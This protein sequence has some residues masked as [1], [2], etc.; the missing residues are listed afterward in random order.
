MNIE[1]KS[2]STWLNANKLTINSKKTHFMVF[3][4]ARIKLNCSDVIIQNET[5]QKT[6]I[7]KY[8]GVIIDDKLKWTDH[9]TYIKKQNIKV[10]RYPI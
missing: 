4:R 2:V 1:L 3:H 7:I 5:L 6:R 9:I 10:N 8:L